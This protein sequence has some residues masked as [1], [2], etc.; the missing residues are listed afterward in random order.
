VRGP[1]GDAPGVGED[2]AGDGEVADRRLCRV[3]RE[4]DLA[5]WARVPLAWPE[6]VGMAPRVLVGGDFVGR[7]PE[8]P[9]ER[10]AGL[11]GA[12][13]VCV[14]Q[15]RVEG[16]VGEWGSGSDGR[17]GVRVVLDVGVRTCGWVSVIS[18]DRGMSVRSVRGNGDA[19]AFGIGGPVEFGHGGREQA[20]AEPSRRIAASILYSLR[21][22]TIWCRAPLF[23]VEISTHNRLVNLAQHECG[24]H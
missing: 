10:A 12:C 4:I 7:V 19:E 8:I 2:P 14:P 21:C 23:S 11:A 16:Q 6:G 20:H 13:A 24:T 17:L 9:G 3:L 5:D 18:S 1:G 22:G 15:K